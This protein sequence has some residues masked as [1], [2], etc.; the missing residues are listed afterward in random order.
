MTRALLAALLLTLGANAQPPFRLPVVETPTMQP[1]RYMAVLITGDGGWAAG[2]RALA[3]TLANEGMPVVALDARAYFG[4]PRTPD[5]T[6]RDW[7][8]LARWYM[9]LWRRDSVVFVGYS[10]G[11]DVAPFVVARLAP[12]LRDR[13]ALVAMIGLSDRASFAFHWADL[14]RDI[15]RPTDL[16]TLPALEQLRGRRMLCFSGNEESGSLCP[17]LDPALATPLLHPGKH[18]LSADAGAAIAGQI[19]AALRQAPGTA[20]SPAGPARTRG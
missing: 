11:A 20:L 4:T 15:P 12:A 18:Q 6:T 17:R 9:P 14:V 8:Q 2:D 16:P 10:R 5:A 19:L 7:E 13:V 3:T 1:G